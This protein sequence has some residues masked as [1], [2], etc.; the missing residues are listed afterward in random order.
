[1]P[2]QGERA[3]IGS[4]ARLALAILC[5]HLV[6]H[7]VRLLRIG[8]GTSLPGRVA[9]VICPDVARTLTRQLND[10]VVLI[11]GTNGKTTTTALVSAAARAHGLAV[12]SNAEGAN[13]VT[14]LTSALIE[15]SDLH[16]RCEATIA[17]F[18]VDEAALASACA[19]L[20]PRA[21]CV[22]NLFR[23]QLD[24]Y[25]ELDALAARIASVLRDSDCALILN[26]DDPM[27]TSIATHVSPGRTVRFFGVNP[28][29]GAAFTDVTV[30]SDCEH[31]PACGFLLDYVQPYYAHIGD[32]VCSRCGFLRP[33]PGTAVVGLGAVQLASTDVDRIATTLS[34]TGPNGIAMVRRPVLGPAEA[35]SVAA[36]LAMSDLMGW[37]S[38]ESAAAITAC[39]PPPGR[40]EIVWVGRTRL[41]LVLVKNPAGMAVSL[42]THALSD[43]RVPILLAV[44][45]NAADGHDSSWIWDAPLE[46]LS[47][48]SGPVIAAGGRA[49][50]VSV[51]L[52]YADVSAEVNEYA[53][54][55]IHQL[56]EHARTT[57]RGLVLANYT[58]MGEL[59]KAAERARA[60]EQ[61]GVQL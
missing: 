40:G 13:L 9:T 45:D 12:V 23:D 46:L 36:A 30:V 3:E 18:E 26:A 20:N 54:D 1:M 35:Y 5:A 32:Y 41:D 38:A 27:V 55:A 49:E 59:R 24:R 47:N 58:A 43:G 22:L 53:P 10:G 48:R 11:T 15:A 50:D 61:A 56:L 4:R 39:P 16:G 14:G 44:N 31:C 8:S 19:L 52:H 7:L 25:A 21:V 34:V 6:T 60:R 28:E 2:E 51:R 33:E 42:R 37:S 57:H 29:V 17:V